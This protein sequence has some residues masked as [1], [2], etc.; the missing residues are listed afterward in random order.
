MRITYIELYN[1]QRIASKGINRIKIDFTEVIQIIIGKNGQGK[2][3]LMR[4]LSPLPPDN[5]DYA[6]GGTK[7]VVLTHKGQHYELLS[8]CGTP[9]R[10][11]FKCNDVE[12]NDSK[13][14]STQKELCETH[15][16]YTGE[17]HELLLGLV[18]G[19]SFTTMSPAKRK[20]WLMTLYPNDLTYVIGL[21]DKFKTM[22]R[23]A[24]G[25]IR[26]S[27]T[28]LTGLYDQRGNGMGV[29]DMQARIDH[30]QLRR[31]RIAR[32]VSDSISTQDHQGNIDRTYSDLKQLVA[33]HRNPITLSRDYRDRDA[34]LELISQTQGNLQQ[35]DF[36]HQTHSKEL[37]ELANNEVFKQVASVDDKERLEQQ[38]DE[39]TKQIA[40]DSDAWALGVSHYQDEPLWQAV[41]QLDE[42]GQRNLVALGN[43]LAELLQNMVAMDNLEVTVAQYD[44]VSKLKYSLSPQIDKL[45][46]TTI[47]LAHRLAH[48]ES[49][50]R[51]Q[52]PQCSHRWIPGVSPQQIEE[53]RTQLATEQAELN[54]LN[55][56]HGKCEHYLTTY[57]A[58][59]Q[60]TCA[61]LRFITGREELLSLHEWFL[62]QL[63]F[64]TGGKSF[65][66]V[67]P[68]IL[69]VL[70]L[71]QRLINKRMELDQLT[72]RLKMFDSD[73]VEWHKRRYQE[74]EDALNLVI[75][76]QRGARLDLAQL[77]TDLRTVDDAQRM[78]AELSRQKGYIHQQVGELAQQKLTQIANTEHQQLGDEQRN[79][80]TQL[81][82][83]RSLEG[84]I[85]TTEQHIESMKQQEEILKL[86]VKATS[87]VEGLVA[88]QLSDFITCFIGNIN[89]VID[90]IWDEVLQIRPCNIEGGSLS[91]KFP[92]LSGELQ[93]E[94][95]DIAES[96]T[97]ESQI[98]NWVFRLVVMDYLGFDEYPLY[99]D[100]IG[101]NF[102]EKHR[103]KLMEYLKKCAS[104]GKYSQIFLISH[105]I[106]QH[107]VFTHAEVCALSTDGVALP[108]RYNEHVVIT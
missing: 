93:C 6:K 44:R 11:S 19:V 57:S 31:D 92:L 49:A 9:S 50:D 91:F 37:S 24:K 20:E 100:E 26:T 88:E 39:L 85:S 67:L 74:H 106:A 54:Q 29:D 89:V 27:S 71:Q 80:T 10:H 14:L 18:N 81:Y 83:S 68:G 12:L 108:E 103:P 87:P 45:N 47:R 96:S 23:D 46:E 107:G 40:Q 95:A 77:N 22:L 55:E 8:V 60:S 5:G 63:L 43:E 65:A 66:A 79:L 48:L 86:L 59:H 51:T 105:Y 15:F 104:S 82:N 35:L 94:T 7:H 38:R 3:S 62:S 13:N 30:L 101:A 53:F 58:W 69:S 75:E 76:Q 90:E 2:S 25:G 73:A 97:G 33:Q 52:C 99:G 41:T 78:I 4:E 42:Q 98:I 64:Y 21:H 36:A 70:P 17:I 34:I 102:D 56:R 32:L 61:Y 16:N 84:S 72:N 1:Y 28:Q